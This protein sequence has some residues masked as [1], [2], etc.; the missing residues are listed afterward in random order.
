MQ[1]KNIKK[2]RQEELEKIKRDR[3]LRYDFGYPSSEI[4]DIRKNEKL[5]NTLYN[6]IK[7]ARIFNRC[8]K[9]FP[10][11]EYIQKLRENEEYKNRPIIVA[12]NHVRKQDIEIIMEAMPEHMILLSGDYENVHGDI[13]GVLLEKNGII[14]FDMENPYESDFI[15]RKE[16]Y[17]RELKE[18]IDLTNNE[19]L[20]KEYTREKKIYDN[21]I[22][23]A[24]NDRANVKN[25]I[26]DIL[27]TG[28]NMLW[29]Y[30]GSWNLSQNKPYY[31]GSYFMVEAAIDTDA[32]VLP[33]S[34]DLIEN[35]FGK[36]AVVRFGNPIDYRNIYGNRKLSDAEK[37]EALDILKGEIGKNIISIW[38][39]YS[40]VNR[41]ILKKK[42]GRS[43][44][45]EEDL[46]LDYKRKAPL[47][48]YFDKYVEKVLGEWHFNEEEIENKHFKDDSIVEQKDAFKHLD[49]IKLNKNNAFLASKRNHF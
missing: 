22:K 23:S 8:S 49:N 7:L 15:K 3:K 30:E 11:K 39:D 44:S 31:D 17:L 16:E 40:L 14:Y 9:D 38:E 46:T 29:F 20:I 37:K 28:Y 36:K 10:S 26:R 2:K 18:Y 32:I 27:N 48:A 25:T 35:K 21:V 24:L 6:L 1:D 47:E 5:H 42:Y 45:I 12:P 34:Y 33:V 4:E 13:G 41:D 19:D 43:P